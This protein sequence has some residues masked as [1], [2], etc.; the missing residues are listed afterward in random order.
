MREKRIKRLPI[1]KKGRVVGLITAADFVRSP[2]VIKMMIHKIRRQ[3]Y[4]DVLTTLE[5]KLEIE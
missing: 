3:I 4:S 1:V 5:A 2:Q